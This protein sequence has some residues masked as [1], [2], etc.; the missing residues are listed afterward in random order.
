MKGKVA[1]HEKVGQMLEAALSWHMK[2]EF[3]KAGLL[4]RKVLARQPRHFDAL[5]LLGVIALQSG[6]PGRAVELIGQAIRVRTDSA[7]AYY[8]R[9]KARR[10][11]RQFQAAI[12]DYD[13]AVALAP[14]EADIHFNRANA[15]R[16][17]KQNMAA[18]ASFEKAIALTPGDPAVHNNCGDA[19]RELGNYRQALESYDKA[20]TLRPDFAFL[21]GMRLHTAMHICAW[22][23]LENDL[24]QLEREIER[25]GMGSPPFQILPMI[26]SAALQ[27]RAAEIWTQQKHPESHSLPSLPKYNRREKIRLGYFSADFHNHATTYLMAELVEKH[28]RNRFELIAFS[29]GPNEN[30]QMRQ[31]MAAAFDRF[32]DVGTKSD[33]EVAELSRSLGVDLAI[34]L[35]GFTRDSRPGIFAARAA[36][37]Q[38]SYL[39]YPG[40]MGAGYID[41]L[42]ADAT[43][44]P[45]SSRQF[46]TEK[47]VY[48]PDSYQPNDSTRVIADL[49]SVRAEH[50]LPSAGFVFCCF[51]NSYKIMPSTF[52]AWMRIL[53]QVDGSVLWLIADTA[54]AVGNL[55]KHAIRCGVAAERLVFAERLSLAEHLARHR[56]ADLFVDTLPCNAHTTASDALWAGLP[57][58]TCTGEAF[59]S[60]VAASLL[61]AVGLPELILGSQSE[62]EA[63]AIELATHPEKLAS[64]TQKLECNRLKTPL[65]DTGRYTRHFEAA[66][67]EM[68]ERYQEDLAP[69][70]IFV[71]GARSRSP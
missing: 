11:L 16:E 68:Y 25:G 18:V 61:N 46:Y 2:G 39:G 48:L 52:E 71:P 8:N 65:F 21:R 60:R 38:V 64:I 69:D 14:G 4:Y 33:A 49:R 1:A 50:G 53:R 63:R 54:D 36:P 22:N 31:R 59:A 47:I 26:N 51:N 5:H 27:K 20:L 13:K 44:I 15:L 3:E 19:L 28:D 37:V 32:I 9:G 7:A 41:Y 17:L 62:Y 30:D 24:S 35:K 10:D 56:L 12:E 23:D 66:C 6:Q 29:F 40:T 67:V 34:D 42:I 57:V 58:L 70:H 43:L 45:Q 55:R